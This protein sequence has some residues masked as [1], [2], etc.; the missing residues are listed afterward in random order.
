M[1]GRFLS[2]IIKFP[3][4]RCSVCNV[5][6]P[7]F[8]PAVFSLCPHSTGLARHSRCKMIRYRNGGGGGTYYV[9]TRY[10]LRHHSYQITLAGWRWGWSKYFTTYYN[11][12]GLLES[13]WIIIPRSPAWDTLGGGEGGAG[14]PPPP[15][16]GFAGPEPLSTGDLACPTQL[17][18]RRVGRIISWDSTY[19]QFWP[20]LLPANISN[21]NNY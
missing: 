1:V 5:V 18:E 3:P 17:Q 21:N 4:A 6:L 14:E 2:R 8:M 20:D 10:P 16:P 7:A 15:T 13:V 19:K 12:D 11:A 9:P